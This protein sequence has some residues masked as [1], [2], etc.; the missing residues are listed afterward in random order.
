MQISETEE[1]LKDLKKLKKKFHT[2]EDDLLILKKVLAVVP[3]GDGTKHWNKITQNDDGDISFFKVRMSCRSLNKGADFRVVYMHDGRQVSLLLIEIYFKGM[4][5]N[6]DMN[7][8]DVFRR[9]I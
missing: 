3:L 2:I 4:K 1:F 8:I 5:E 9:N 7:R 6:N